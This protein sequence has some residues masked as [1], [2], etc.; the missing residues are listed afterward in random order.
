MKMLRLAAPA[1]ALAALACST[2]EVKT[3]SAPGADFSKYKTF[4]LGAFTAEAGPPPGS[5]DTAMRFTKSLAAALE[6][7]G[8]KQVPE[9]GDLDVFA[10]FGLGKDAVLATYLARDRPGQDPD[11]RDPG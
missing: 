11:E 2:L 5:P 7:R 8:L 1:I 3:D 6:A 9:G 4:T 10:R